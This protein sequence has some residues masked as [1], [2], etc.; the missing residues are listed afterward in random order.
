MVANAYTTVPRYGVNCRTQT[1]SIAMLTRPVT[2]SIVRTPAPPVAEGREV[3]GAVPDG[4]AS[5]P[6]GIR[7]QERS[8]APVP[9]TTFSAAAARSVPTNP[10]SSTRT[11][12]EATVPQ[13]APRT[14]AT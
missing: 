7:T 6:G 2:N 12:A 13:V 11:K 5:V 9:I 8:R 1:T 3:A 10:R 14:L 4:T